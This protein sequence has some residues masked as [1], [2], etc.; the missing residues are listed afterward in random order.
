MSGLIANRAGGSATVLTPIAAYRLI[1]VGRIGDFLR[2]TATRNGAVL[3]PIT[4]DALEVLEHAAEL[5]RPSLVPLVPLGIPELAAT[6][7]LLTTKQ[8]AEKAH[9]S[10][11]WVR[12]LVEQ[13]HLTRHG[14]GRRLLVDEDELLQFISDNRKEIL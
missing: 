8:A 2:D 4:A 6:G 11:R 1:R 13:R 5:Y 3:D 14:S 7:N 12:R 9:W 10:E